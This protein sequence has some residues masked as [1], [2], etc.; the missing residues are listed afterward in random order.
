MFF[1]FKKKISARELG[2]PLFEAFMGMQADDIP[3][4]AEHSVDIERLTFELFCLRAAAFYHGLEVSIADSSLCLVAHESL[5][6][7][8][9][10]GAAQG[11]APRDGLA[12]LRRMKEYELAR[13]DEVHEARSLWVG[14]KFSMFLTG[15]PSFRTASLA[16]MVFLGSA[17]FVGDALEPYR[18]VP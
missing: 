3:R 8:F 11:I 2:A 5:I 10:A 15:A 6:R 16:Q 13:L 17:K 14:H 7:S 9:A 18:I 4:F 12:V 1:R